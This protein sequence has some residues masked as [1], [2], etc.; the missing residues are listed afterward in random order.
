MVK[1]MVARSLGIICTCSVV[2]D[3]VWLHEVGM[4]F[5]HGWQQLPDLWSS[6]VF[7]A[8]LVMSRSMRSSLS[9]K[10]SKS[11]VLQVVRFAIG[12]WNG[13]GTI[14]PPDLAF[15]LDQRTRRS[16]IAADNFDTVVFL[17]HIWSFSLDIGHMQG[18]VPL[19]WKW[20]PKIQK[21]H[22]SE[23]FTLLLEA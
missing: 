14:W 7:L 13:E 4:C 22:V 20:W 6:S 19:H 3:S 10:S 2:P 21:S 15:F 17:F 12:Y 1:S 8:T 11:F 18:H 16:R 23:R 5:P 9:P